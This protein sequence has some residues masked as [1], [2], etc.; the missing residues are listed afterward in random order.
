MPGWPPLFVHPLRCQIYERSIVGTCSGP[1]GGGVFPD[2]DLPRQGSTNNPKLRQRGKQRI[3]SGVI[4]KRLANVR[5]TI[6]VAGAEDETSPKLKR[7]LPELV[8]MMTRRPR[9]FSARGVILAKKMQQICRPEP[10]H[11]IG[12]ALLVN[13]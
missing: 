4:S 10:R 8:L 3:G 13:Q 9:A 2:Y 11:S 5:K 6:D 12:P 7:I 1:G